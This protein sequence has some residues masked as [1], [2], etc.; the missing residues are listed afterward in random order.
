MSISLFDRKIRHST[1]K[2]HLADV[3]RPKKSALGE[4]MARIALTTFA[5]MKKPYGH[6]EVQGFLDRTPAVFQEVEHSPGFIARAPVVQLDEGRA[7]TFERAW[8]SWG[9]LRVP[10]YYPGGRTARTDS[11]ASTLS[12]WTDLS[13]ASHFVYKG[14]FH[15]D[16]LKRRQEWFLKPEWPSYALWWVEDTHIPTWEEACLRL[17]HLYDHGASP[18][19]FTFKSAFDAAGIPLPFQQ[20]HDSSRTLER[21]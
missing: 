21:G 20:F 14:P 17:E 15:R 18:V 12:L 4:F 19:A 6:P 13:S 9:P 3:F 1:Q 8:G 2:P 11:R 16:A 7:G 5:L 10:R